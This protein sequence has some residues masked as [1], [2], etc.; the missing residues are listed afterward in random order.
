MASPFKL[1]AVKDLKL[2]PENPRLPE[3]L[4]GGAQS[5]ILTYLFQTTALDELAQSY[6]DNGFFPHEPLII[7]ERKDKDAKYVVLE[8]NRR[9]ATLMVLLQ[10]PESADL[11][12]T[13]VELTTDQRNRL[14]SVP[15]YPIASRKE[16]HAFLGFRHI[17]GIKTWE[18]EA[19]ARYLLGEVDRAHEA[20][21]P[22]PFRDVGRRVGSNAVGVRN[23]YMSLSILR[24]AR[25]QFGFDTAYIQLN[26]FGVW[27]RCMN[28][29]EIRQFIGLDTPRTYDEI[30][31]ALARLKAEHLQEVLSDLVPQAGRK[32]PLLADSRDVTDYGRVI[33]NAA[34]RRVLRKYEDL[35]VAAEVID[36][37]ELASRIR[38]ITDSCKVLLDEVTRAEPSDDLVSAARELYEIARSIQ[39]I[40]TGL[41]ADE[42]DRR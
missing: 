16:L 42:P 18:A 1:Y 25:E 40:T 29:P 31:E 30:K 35:S 11:S 37:E 14:R 8:G 22:D 27:L 33:A 5:E 26:R 21:S 20:G 36:R 4:H 6:Q 2:D 19:K 28:S 34:A 7:L 9:L 39:S 10:T 12:F 41:K 32:K 23:P 3:T 13:T 17:G 15:C 24:H 38:R